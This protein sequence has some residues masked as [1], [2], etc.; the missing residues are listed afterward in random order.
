[1]N[2]PRK[3][4]IKAS[5]G[6]DLNKV[7]AET[8]WNMESARLVEKYLDQALKITSAR[9]LDD[10]YMPYPEIGS[11]PPIIP[12]EWKFDW[13]R[14][15]QVPRYEPILYYGGIPQWVEPNVWIEKQWE[16]QAN[17]MSIT[18]RH[19]FKPIP[20][21]IPYSDDCWRVGKTKSQERI[22]KLRGTGF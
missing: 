5:R 15:V 4:V 7:A 8:L 18:P 13:V 1:M 11:V 10:D 3:N 9:I 16:R 22:Q 14:F 6:A 20:R 2:E 17:V 12:D 19:I 21:L